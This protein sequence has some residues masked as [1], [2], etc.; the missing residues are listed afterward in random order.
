MYD[1]VC[2]YMETRVDAG[3]ISTLGSSP[4]WYLFQASWSANSWNP[5]VSSLALGLQT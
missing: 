3:N 4:L 5:P 1:S 2:M